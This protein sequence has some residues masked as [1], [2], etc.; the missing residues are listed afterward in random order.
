MIALLVFLIVVA[1]VVVQCVKNLPPHERG[2]V[3]R[4]GKP[5][6]GPVGPGLVLIMPAVDR[7]V[8]V[9][10]AEQ[11]VDVPGHSIVFRV[12]DPV[13]AVTVVSDYRKAIGDLARKLI[14]SQAEHVQ[15]Q[16]SD[17]AEPWGI[18]IQSVKV[19]RFAGA[20]SR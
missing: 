10:V 4:L 8:R 14:D 18:Q 11:K 5:L 15:S 13:R 16:L 6:P 12:I 1:V 9:T 17:A 20:S 19:N 2:V 7:L 3:F